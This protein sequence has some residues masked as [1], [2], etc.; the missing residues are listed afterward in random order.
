M[1]MLI[2]TVSSF[3][4]SLPNCPSFPSIPQLCVP[5]AP[6]YESDKIKAKCNQNTVNMAC[7]RGILPIV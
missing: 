3:F 1:P 5:H 2:T 6:L 4:H 7:G